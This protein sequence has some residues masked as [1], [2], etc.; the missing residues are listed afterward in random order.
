M[1]AGR[2][3]RDV[4]ERQGPV[5]G[6]GPEAIAAI[7]AAKQGLRVVVFEGRPWLRR[8]LCLAETQRYRRS[9]LYEKIEGLASELRQYSNVRIFTQTG[10]NGIWGDNLVT[11]VQAGGA[12]DHF[13]ERYIEVRS[14]SVVIATGC[15]ER[16]LVFENNERP[17]VM[18]PGC[19][20]GLQ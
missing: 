12:G 19:A 3:R 1:A 4:P 11:A 20:Q 7:S 8:F 16:P 10:V 17:G 14:R 2:I 18:Q 9:R 6:A 13:S 15:N 5:V